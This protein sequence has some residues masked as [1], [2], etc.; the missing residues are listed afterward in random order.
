MKKLSEFIKEKMDHL[1][2]FEAFWLTSHS[3]DPDNFPLGMDNDNSGMWEE[4]FDIF[5]RDHPE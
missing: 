2:A 1:K 3:S 5:C 4:Q